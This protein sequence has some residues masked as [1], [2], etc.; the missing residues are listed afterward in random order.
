MKL[1]IQHFGTAIG[2]GGPQGKTADGTG[3][4]KI[5]KTGDRE[6]RS[7][8]SWDRKWDRR[9]QILG[10]ADALLN[11]QEQESKTIKTNILV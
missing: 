10:T 1:A 11:S 6:R 2:T 9:S 7:K 4:P 8:Y 5:F 3:G